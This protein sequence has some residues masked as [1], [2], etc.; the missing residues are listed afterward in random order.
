MEDGRNNY[1]DKEQAKFNVFLQYFE[2]T[3]IGLKDC[4]MD[5]VKTNWIQDFNLV[6]LGLFVT[7]KSNPK[8]LCQL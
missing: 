8:Q 4:K 1:Y 6:S 5:E 7:H 3:L 2:W